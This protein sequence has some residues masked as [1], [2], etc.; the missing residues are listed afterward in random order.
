MFPD[1]FVYGAEER[2]ERTACPFVQEVGQ[3]AGDGEEEEGGDGFSWKECTEKAAADGF[4]SRN[5]CS[6]ISG[7][8]VGKV[9]GE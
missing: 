2:E 7:D 6:A 9:F 3:G 1:G 5:V 8:E 4:C